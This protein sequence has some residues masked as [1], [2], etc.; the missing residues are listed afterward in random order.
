M[1]GLIERFELV[2]VVRFGVG[3]CCKSMDH[4]SCI[5]SLDYANLHRYV[6]MNSD[7]FGNSGFS[8]CF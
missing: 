2:M 4:K 8:S 7:G 6:V 1:L 5:E 3:D